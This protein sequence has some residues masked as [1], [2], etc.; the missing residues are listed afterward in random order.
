MKIN[1]FSFPAAVSLVAALLTSVTIY[2]DVF[3]VEPH[4]QS[5][6]LA[7]KLG[8]ILLT[9]GISA[10]FFFS[11]RLEADTPRFI[12]F[13][14]CIA[15][16]LSMM[17]F[18]P[19]YEAAYLQCAIGCAFIKTKRQWLFPSVF[20][21]GMLGFLAMYELQDQLNWTVPP[22]SRKDW[23]TII[24]FFFI[25]TW[26]IQKYAINTSRREKERL[27]R[28][29][30]IGHETQRLLHDVKGMLSSP[31][32]LF[33]SI[34]ADASQ[35]TFEGYK[36]Q[37]QNLNSEMKHVRDV[38]RSV[39]LMSKPQKDIREVCVSQAFGNACQILERR[40]KNIE[41]SSLPSRMVQS[42][43]D[44]L[45]SVFFN[46]LLN[47]MEA[48]ERKKTVSPAIKV[49]WKNETLI[50]QDNAGTL[51]SDV[52]DEGGNSGIGLEII[53]ADLHDLGISARISFES[54]G[55]HVSMR[56]PAKT[57]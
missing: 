29:S 47:S 34:N 30:R 5:I 4:L 18:L 52:R 44:V 35:W 20:G 26:I 41:T 38:L 57:A 45:R 42:D 36:A 11:R 16:C 17:W 15:Y 10:F 56:F 49:F 21:F 9:L 12:L 22:P 1:S 53:H 6:F 31:I 33:E 51:S 37:V 32:L 39:N 46:L 27:M 7:S 19:L 3:R 54:S 48:F 14:A 43:E 23:I 55:L 40:L 28:L 50:Y 13:V 25:L 2:P 8:F 24:L